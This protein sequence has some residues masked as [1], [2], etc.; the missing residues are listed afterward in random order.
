[1]P[2]TDAVLHQPAH[3]HLLRPAA[4]TVFTALRAW[5]DTA[6]S[7]ETWWLII[8]YDAQHYTAIRFGEL[9][10]MLV[11][12]KRTAHMNTPLADLPYRRANPDDPDH[13]LPGVISPT[14]VDGATLDSARAIEMLQTGPGQM[15]VVLREGRFQ[16]ILSVAHPTFV[17]FDH[18]LL[19]LL[20]TFEMGGESETIIV[21][22]SSPEDD[23]KPG[24]APGSL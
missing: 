9:R 4:E 15:L 10:D 20:E 8:Q 21:P 12:R 11:G 22:R 7:T 1:M 19:D 6:G 5:R 13:P 16:G 2:I 24:G 3:A 18:P 23:T 17:Y 14:I